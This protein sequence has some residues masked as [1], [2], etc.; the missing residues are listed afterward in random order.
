MTAQDSIQHYMVSI[1]SDA[2]DRQLLAKTCSRTG[3]VFVKVDKAGHKMEEVLEADRAVQ[4]AFYFPS[5]FRV[6]LRREGEMIID[7]YILNSNPPL[8]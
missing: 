8:S 6:T 4:L 1:Q 7:K 5:E 2:T 3:H